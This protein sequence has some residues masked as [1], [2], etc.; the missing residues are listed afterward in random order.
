MNEERTGPK[1]AALFSVHMLV[2][3]WGRQYTYGELKGIL[4]K[5]G[6]VNINIAPTSTHYCVVYGTKP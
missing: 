2:Y 1:V 4:E 5:V 6:F 3:T